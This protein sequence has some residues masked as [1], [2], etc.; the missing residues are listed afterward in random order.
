[1]KL[2]FALRDITEKGGGEKVCANLVN[3][4]VENHNVTIVSF[5]KSADVLSYTINENIKIHYLNNSGFYSH[6]VIKYLYHKIFFRFYLNIRLFYFIKKTVPDIVICNDGMFKP[7]IKNRKVK[8]VRIWHITTPKRKKFI[9]RFFDAIVILSGKSLPF[10]LRI[11]NNIKVIHNFLTHF[12]EKSSSCMNNIALSIGKIDKVDTKGFLRLV[13]IWSMMDVGD[14]M[15][16]YIV[17]DGDGK[18]VLEERV[19]MLHLEES[20]KIFPFDNDIEK[21]YLQAGV[22]L[23]T[24]Y[25]EGMGMTLLEAASYGLPCM[26]FDI[27][28][29]PGDIIQNDIT[30]FLINDNDLQTYAEKLSFL[31]QHPEVRMDMGRK[32]KAFVEGKFSKRTIIGQWEALFE[33]LTERSS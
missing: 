10:W 29:G 14:D 27:L 20:V 24:S 22:C 4:L 33:E 26:S 2:L 18:S 1:M 3:N 15:F 13:H 23:S 19:R 28:T 30:G 31:M 8:Y 12:P 5:F 7:F 9:F 17:G 6:S 32:A 16:L 25:K 11:I 21:Y